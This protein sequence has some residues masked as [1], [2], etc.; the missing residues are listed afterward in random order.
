MPE[1]VEVEIACRMLDQ[2]IL[3]ATITLVDTVEAGGGPRTGHA[4][5]PPSLLGTGG[6]AGCR[7]RLH[8]C[9]RRTGA[10]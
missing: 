1:G 4:M 10:H 9:G 2:H 3:G 5:F 8:T 7:V 6:W